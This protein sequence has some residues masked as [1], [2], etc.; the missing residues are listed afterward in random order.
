MSGILVG[1]LATLAILAVLRALRFLAWRR[2][3]PRSSRHG[4]RSGW[5]ARRLARRI[6]AT[7]EQERLL[8]EE[9]DAVRLALREARMGFLASREDLARALEADEVDASSLESMG[10]RELARLDAV[11]RRATEA[12]ARVHAALDGRQRRALAEL[13][14]SGGHPAPRAAR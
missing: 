5:M 10:A 7:P 1:V 6:D 2:R 14:R 13:L 4:P 11:R 9:M 8:L 12:L 3:W